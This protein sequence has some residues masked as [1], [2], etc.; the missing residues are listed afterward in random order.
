[1]VFS[2]A[3][4]QQQTPEAVS[5]IL[6]IHLPGKTDSEHVNG[7]LSLRH[8]AGSILAVL[9]PLRRRR[10]ALVV[11]HFSHSAAIPFAEQAL[12]VNPRDTDALSSLALYQAKSGEREKARQLI[13]RALAIAPKDVDVLGEAA[14]VFAVTGEEQKALDC[15]K[16]AV[17]GGYP[18]FEIEANPELAG[19]RNSPAYREIMARPSTEGSGPVK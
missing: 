14:E 18:R 2:S 13:G 6:R 12:A 9:G 11:R 16:S 5:L 3:D 1:L 8:G 4:E 19:V 10:S 7:E 17:Q 15:L